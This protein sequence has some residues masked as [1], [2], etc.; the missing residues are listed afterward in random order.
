MSARSSALP[1]RPASALTWTVLLLAQHPRVASDLVDEVDGRLKGD[2]PS[3][4]QLGDMPLLDHVVKESLRVIP[5]VPVTWRIAAQQVELGGYA[6]PQGTEV[7]G[8]TYHTHHVPRL[9]GGG[10]L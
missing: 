4:D 2:P 8:S 7:Y 9:F 10:V 5:P 3:A 6:V 1:T